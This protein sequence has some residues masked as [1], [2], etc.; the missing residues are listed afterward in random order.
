M[1]IPSTEKSHMLTAAE[2]YKLSA[3]MTAAYHEP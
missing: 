1:D 3:V 2:E